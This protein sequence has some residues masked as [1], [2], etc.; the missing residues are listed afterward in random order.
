MNSDD[1]QIVQLNKTTLSLCQTK[2]EGTYRQLKNAVHT[3]INE[4][5]ITYVTSESTK[6]ILLDDGNHC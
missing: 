1:F 4:V 3:T 2:E 5:N 6:S